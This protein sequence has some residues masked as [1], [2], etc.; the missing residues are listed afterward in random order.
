MTTLAF[1]GKT[2]D[3]AGL[4][5]A[6][7]LANA[8]HNVPLKLLHY[9]DPHIQGPLPLDRWLE[10]E[11]PGQIARMGMPEHILAAYA[12]IVSRGGEHAELGLQPDGKSMRL[13]PAESM[14]HHLHLLHELWLG[15]RTVLGS[16]GEH[17]PDDENH[18][19]WDWVSLLGQCM[20]RVPVIL[21]RWSEPRE[22]AF[23]ESA[24]RRAS[25]FP[26]PLSA[27]WRKFVEGARPAWVKLGPSQEEAPIASLPSPPPAQR[28]LDRSPNADSRPPAEVAERRASSGF[29]FRP[30][31]WVT[32]HI[33]LGSAVSEE[34]IDV[35]VRDGIT[36]V[37]DCRLGPGSKA[38]YERTG[39]VYLQIG[40]ADDGKPKADEWFWSGI[41]FATRA[42]RI[43]RSR[44]LVH[45]KM[46]MSRS[47]TMVYAI[48]LTQGRSSEDAQALISKSRIVAKVTYETDARR[49]AGRW[50][51]RSKV[52]P[53]AH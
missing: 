46:G 22:S 24:L 39:I 43:P 33:A 19:G 42:L 47:P 9:D 51:R 3:R 25:A 13:A 41:D 5:F 14:R 48:L 21:V 53:K 10:R 26:E 31:Q 29:R 6:G 20:R 1:Y 30:Y 36:H 27:I 52:G 38:L 40:V 37:I 17:V 32:E 8:L 2:R 45:C 4:R 23:W 7:R 16:G 15:L 11:F 49:A 44:L 18:I 50:V 35:L 12:S 28:A 34:D